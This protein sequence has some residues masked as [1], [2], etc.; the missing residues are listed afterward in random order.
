MTVQNY[1]T[2]LLGTRNA[3]LDHRLKLNTEENAL[4]AISDENQQIPMRLINH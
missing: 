3:F 4:N 1:S 2:D